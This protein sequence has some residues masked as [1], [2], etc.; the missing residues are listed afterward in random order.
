MFVLSC[1]NLFFLY[2]GVLGL[3]LSGVEARD[4]SYIQELTSQVTLLPVRYGS[5]TFKGPKPKT[6]Y[7]LA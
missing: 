5:H 4:F 6:V 7:I 3:H 2:G 1:L